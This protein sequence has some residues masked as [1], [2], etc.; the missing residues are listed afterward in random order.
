M[1]MDDDLKTTTK[2][3]ES[4]SEFLGAAGLL[5]QVCVVF[6]LKADRSNGVTAIDKRS[7]A[8]SVKV[9]K[10]GLFADVQADRVHH[11]G[12]DQAIYV[13]SSEEAAR[14]GA[15]LEREIPAGF[16]GE[17]LRVSGIN[18]SD[19]IV[20]ER[21]RIGKH[22]EVEVTLPRVPCS[23][24]A[25]HMDDP[26]WVSRF[27][28]RGDIGCYLRVIR[29]GKISAGDEIRV[30]SRPAHGV[31]IRQVFTGPTPAQATALLD[32]ERAI[33]KELPA[34]IPKKLGQLGFLNA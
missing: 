24:F 16:F 11:G 18:T 3:R 26:E 34:K 19:A 14:W 23:T 33:G 13:Y 29:V 28:E 15:E 9:N 8:G 27:T 22:V 17:N 10:I 1:A 12:F 6:A 20:G 5:E 7:V 32:D 25:R 31:S 21:W 4:T 2:T 30:L